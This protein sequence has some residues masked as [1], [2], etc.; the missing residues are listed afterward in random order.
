MH[1]LNWRM[2]ELALTF[3]V[4]AYYSR[5]SNFD[6]TGET[7][8][9]IPERCYSPVQPVATCEAH[10]DD[11]PISLTPLIARPCVLCL[12]LHR[13]MSMSTLVCRCLSAA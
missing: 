11:L 7:E 1:L 5:V 12:C 10:E 4:M 8:G 9:R 6:L 3:S 13:C 2:Y